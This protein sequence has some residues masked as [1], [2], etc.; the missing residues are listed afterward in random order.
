MIEKVNKKKKDS[1]LWL[2]LGPRNSEI[3]QEIFKYLGTASNKEIAQIVKGL[4]YDLAKG[5]LKIVKN[6]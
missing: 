6:K 2:N 3:N 1:D 4:F 5:H